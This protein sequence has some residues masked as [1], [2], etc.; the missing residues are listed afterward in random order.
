MNLNKEDIYKTLKDSLEELP[1]PE[2]TEADWQSF[3]SFSGSKEKKKKPLV[4]Y[5]LPSSFLLGILLIGSLSLVQT[6]K[7]SS[8]SAETSVASRNG[9]IAKAIPA[10]AQKQVKTSKQI[11]AKQKESA[12]LPF[13]VTQKNEETQ[14]IEPN[15]KVESNQEV[16][17]K[18]ET[19][20][21]T[22]IQSSIPSNMNSP[23]WLFP[24]QAQAIKTNQFYAVPDKLTLGSNRKIKMPLQADWIGLWGITSLSNESTKGFGAGFQLG[25]EFGKGWHV[26]AGLEYAYTTQTKTKFWNHE[27]KSHDLIKI[28]TNLRMDV[29]LTKII[30]VMDSVFEYRDHTEAVKHKTQTNTNYID[31]PLEIGYTLNIGKL[32]IGSNLGIYNRFRQTQ[33]NTIETYP[34]SNAMISDSQ[35]KYSFELLSSIGVSLAY[36]LSKRL[37]VQASPNLLFNPIERKTSYTETR[38]R[39]GIKYYLN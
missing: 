35:Q 30:M 6:E 28:D 11:E 22:Q 15:Q 33:T 29:S 8:K 25:K 18:D 16:E 36:P 27:F 4:W 7:N 26:A 21:V 2:A 17:S 20:E 1:M 10:E 12:I 19:F 3:K 5:I 39:M 38:L 13:E 37:W 23:I 9:F 31:I 14:S 32:G 34:L 24:F